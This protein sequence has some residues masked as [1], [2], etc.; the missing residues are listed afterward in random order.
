MRRILR[1][2]LPLAV[3]AVV[4]AT[5]ACGGSGDTESFDYGPGDAPSPAEKKLFAEDF[6]A[7]CEGATVSA[8]KPYDAAASGHKAVY[9]KSYKDSGLLDSS[10]DLPKDWTVEYDPNGNVYAEIDIVVCAK[11]TSE[12]LAK[13]CDGY[14]VDDK[15]NPLV[16]KMHTAKYTVTAHEAT[17]GKELGKTT[18]AA[19]DGSCPT[20]VFGI[21][22]GTTT[23]ND[24]ASPPDEK[25]VAFAKKFIQP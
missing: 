9:L 10:T 25:I 22:E 15:P 2:V 14:K 16:V 23:M 12:K 18:V 17:T 3:V 1:G 6:K 4:A 24:Y 7:V 13:S 19:N 11:R 21:E 20:S 8:A 5:T